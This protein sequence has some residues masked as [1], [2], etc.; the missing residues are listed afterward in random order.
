VSDLWY[1]DDRNDVAKYLDA[2]GWASLGTTMQQLLAMNG[3]PP[4]PVAEDGVSV[5]AN[6]YYT[7]ILT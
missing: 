6:V 7:S 2:R 1:H 4:A 3:L 5:A